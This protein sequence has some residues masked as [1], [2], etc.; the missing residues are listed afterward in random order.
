MKSESERAEKSS[1]MLE[2]CFHPINL[3]MFALK[4]KTKKKKQTNE[5][6]KIIKERERE[7][8]EEEEKT[9]FTFI[10]NSASLLEQLKKINNFNFN[11]NS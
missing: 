11:N 2:N 7:R 3:V 4:P 1:E 9:L 8:S 10:Q 6:K 5:R